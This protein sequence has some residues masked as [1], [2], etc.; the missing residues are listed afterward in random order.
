PGLAALELRGADVDEAAVAELQRKNPLCRV[1]SVHPQLRT[2][3]T[4]PVREA[5]RLL[6][7]QGIDLMLSISDGTASRGL[8]AST[9]LENTLPCDI[10]LITLNPGTMPKL[11]A[12]LL[13]PMRS[14]PINQL[15]ISQAFDADAIIK[16]LPDELLVRRIELGNSGLT[17][18]GLLQL[19]RISRPE[20]LNVR[21]TKV[22]SEGT[23]A[24]SKAVPGCVVFGSP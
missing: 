5:I 13:L 9:A 15:W 23:T 16:L 3:G 22:T 20:R 24:F 12:S 11:D 7:N 18:Q 4:D 8:A 10:E 19:S 6:H 1:V 2:I 14:V 17:D 21:K